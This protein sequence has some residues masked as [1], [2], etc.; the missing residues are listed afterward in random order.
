MFEEGGA[1]MIASSRLEQI[2]DSRNYGIDLPYLLLRVP[3]M[4]ELPE[5][6]SLPT[7]ALTAKLK[8]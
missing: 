3:M 4:T 1:K 2:E 6:V 5:V 7:S 8:C